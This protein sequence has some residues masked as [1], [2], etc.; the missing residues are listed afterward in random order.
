MNLPPIPKR[1]AHLERIGDFAVP[2]VTEWTRPSTGDLIDQHPL[3]GPSVGCDCAPGEGKPVF[4]HTCYARQRQAMEG[5]LCGVCGTQLRA[6]YVWHKLGD[7]PMFQEPASH[8]ACLVYAL[9]A[10]PALREVVKHP[11]ATVIEASGYHLGYE[12]TTKANGDGDLFQLG[13]SGTHTVDPD[14][15]IHIRPVTDPLSV[16]MA[17]QHHMGY[18]RSYFAEPV[19]YSTFTVKDWLRRQRESVFR[20]RQS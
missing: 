18:F 16:P 14:G 15:G 8:A 12:R 7:A 5:P 19:D 10:C 13:Q 6:P 1:L 20:P 17:V 3:C 2:W 11:N 4:K 9:A